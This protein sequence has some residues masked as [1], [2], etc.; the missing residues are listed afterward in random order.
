MVDLL[1]YG[2]N[3]PNVAVTRQA[4]NRVFGAVD[5]WGKDC[6][7]PGA[8]DGTGIL[9]GFMDGLLAQLRA[10]IR[11][12]GKTAGLADIVQTNNA[13]DTMALKAI[14]HLIQRGQMS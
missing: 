6:T 7:S 9:H 2:S 12:N 1:G 11:G 14:Q 5:T 10:L 13:D 4:D 8:G 3:A